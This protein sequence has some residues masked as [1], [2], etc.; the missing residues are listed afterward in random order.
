MSRVEGQCIVGEIIDNR[1]NETCDVSGWRKQ[2][3]KP[4]YIWQPTAFLTPVCNIIWNTIIFRYNRFRG[5][6]CRLLSIIINAL[7]GFRHRHSLYYV[8][9]REITFSDDRRAE[10]LFNKNAS[11]G[12]VWDFS[13][14]P[15][16]SVVICDNDNPILSQEIFFKSQNLRLP[17][18]KQLLMN[19][20]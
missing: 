8:T 12:N 1:R 9:C 11:L 3:P 19:V 10:S 16:V 17:T 14:Q 2:S 7:P 20:H 6:V 4:L 13:Q 15:N 18:D 5:S